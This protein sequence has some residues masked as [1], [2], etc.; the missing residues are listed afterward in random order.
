LKQWYP[1]LKKRILDRIAK[2][3]SEL[4][5]KKKT[6]PEKMA[7]TQIPK[8]ELKNQKRFNLINH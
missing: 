6:N 7:E 3:E 4:N 8:K 2:M 1:W 5:S